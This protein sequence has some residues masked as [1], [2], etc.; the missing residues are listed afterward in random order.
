MSKKIETEAPKLKRSRLQELKA[1][2]AKVTWPSKK[3]LSKQTIAVIVIA[4]TLGFLIAGIDAL[5]A[6][7]LF[8]LVGIGG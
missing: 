7:G 6:S 3:D 8:K 5:I 2:F 4:I 1:E